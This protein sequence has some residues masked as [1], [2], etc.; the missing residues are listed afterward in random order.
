MSHFCNHVW[1]H[2]NLFLIRRTNQNNVKDWCKV[3]RFKESM[4][5]QFALIREVISQSEPKV[6]AVCDRKQ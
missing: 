1:F 3:E 6:I 4:I 5:R 2:L